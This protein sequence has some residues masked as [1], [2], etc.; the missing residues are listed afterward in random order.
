MASKTITTVIYYLLPSGENPV[1]DFIDSLPKIPKT[2]IFRVIQNI[3]IYGL[4][5]VIPHVKKLS[6]IPLWEIRILGKD[7]IRVLYAIVINN[8]VLLND[9]RL[10]YDVNLS[11]A[12]YRFAFNMP[13]A[14][15]P[16]TQ[17][18]IML[19]AY[20]GGLV[21]MTSEAYRSIGMTPPPGTAETIQKQ[22]A[23]V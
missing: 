2:K 23:L 22:S 3:E 9:A 20:N 18:R 12:P 13:D 19:D 1:K 10:N 5:S 4:V 14:L 21:L 17:S 7:N 6:G 11:E 8:Q 16:E 15:D